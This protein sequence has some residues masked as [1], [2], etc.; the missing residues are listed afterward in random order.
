MSILASLVNAYARLPNAPSFGYSAE[1]ISFM[2]SLNTDGSVAH[3]IDMR[4]GEG[5]KKQP[6]L[7][8]VPQPEKSAS[9]IA[10]K[11][12]WGNT[13][14]LL[15]VTAKQSENKKQNRTEKEHKAFIERHVNLLGAS[16]DEGLKALVLF[17]QNWSRDQFIAPLWPDEMKDQNIIFALESERLSNIFLHNRPEAKRIWT[18]LGGEAGSVAQICLVTGE[19]APVARLHPS[20]KGVWGAQSSGAALVSFNLD[21]FTSYGHEQGDNA[22]VSEGAASLPIPRR[23]T[24]FW[25][26]RAAIACR[27]AM[28]PPCS[29]RMRRIWQR[30]PRPFSAFVLIRQTRK[31]TRQNKRLNVPRINLRIN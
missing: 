11:F 31:R 3:V 22:L 20:I 10:P 5:K 29:G 30:M 26:A 4:E 24:A 15:G 28:P 21:A 8:Q 13:S 18:R 16:E 1:K 25:S 9:K 6:R 27:S 19:S 7:M 17:L 12:L 2:I 14:Y 23:T